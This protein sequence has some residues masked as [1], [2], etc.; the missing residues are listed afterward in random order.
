MTLEGFS[1]SPSFAVP[2]TSWQLEQ[3]M[4]CVY[5]TL[6]TKS[7]PCIRFLWAAPSAK[8]VKVVSPRFLL[9][10]APVIAKLLANVKTHG[11]IIVLAFDR[12]LQ[13]L[14]LRMTL[15]TDIV[16]LD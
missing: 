14:A 12:I 1:N 6:F 3:V 15:D 13:R 9:F 7:L 16:R 2:C 4:P 5:I 10:Q 11:P 8:W